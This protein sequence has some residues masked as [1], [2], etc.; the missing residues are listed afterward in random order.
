MSAAVSNAVEGSGM[1]GDAPE[2]STGNEDAAD[3]DASKRSIGAGANSVETNGNGCGGGAE[4]RSYSVET[5]GNGCGG[6]AEGRSYSVETN[7]ATGGNVD[8]RLRD[9]VETNDA[10]GGNV[11]GR[12]RDSVETNGSADRVVD[13]CVWL[14]LAPRIWL[15]SHPSSGRDTGTNGSAV[16]GAAVGMI[17]SGLRDVVATDDPGTGSC[18]RC[19]WTNGSAG[20][21]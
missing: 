16:A 9:S 17:V 14:R 10:T 15:S 21:V 18:T 5:N 11:E 7:D 19:A 8:G 4:G 2:R 1:F 13:S 12:L 20:A 3:C 6:G